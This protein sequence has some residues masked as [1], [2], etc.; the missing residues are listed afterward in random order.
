MGEEVVLNETMSRFLD[1]AQWPFRSLQGM[2]WKIGISS[3]SEAS[4]WSH[5]T[6]HELL[7]IVV[8]AYNP[9]TQEEK[10]G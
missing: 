8:H 7:S 2:A 10:A 1:H 3:E 4:G 5:E 6:G 9:N